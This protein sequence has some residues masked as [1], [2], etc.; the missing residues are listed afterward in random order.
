MMSFE[1]RGQDSLASVCGFCPFFVDS[2]AFFV[3]FEPFFG[4]LDALL[5]VFCGRRTALVRSEY[6]PE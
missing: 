5:T 1:Q 4:A 6:R 2:A 3:D